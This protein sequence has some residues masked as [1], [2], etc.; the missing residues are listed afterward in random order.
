[1]GTENKEQ[2]KTCTQPSVQIHRCVSVLPNDYSILENLPVIN[3]V[4][5]KGNLTSEILSLLSAKSEDFVDATLD[6]AK[7]DDG[8]MI[9]VLPG[10][11]PKKVSLSYLRSGTEIEGGFQTVDEVNTKAA[12]GSYQFVEKK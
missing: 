12:V 6:E 9:V 4:V 7:E 3:G 8:Y 2:E 5:I 11:K 10:N 1:M